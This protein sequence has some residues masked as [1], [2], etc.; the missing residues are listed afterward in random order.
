MYET[1]GE[2]PMESDRECLPDYEKKA[3]EQAGQLRVIRTFK[4]SLI[5]FIQVIRPYTRSDKDGLPGLL[6]TLMINIFQREK[7]LDR[8]L[9]LAGKHK[10]G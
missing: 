3:E 7:E 5:E 9:E 10:D 1:R 8:T 2:A 6:G 4:D